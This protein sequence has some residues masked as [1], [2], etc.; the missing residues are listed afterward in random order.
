M[1]R[2]HVHVDAVDLQDGVASGPDGRD[3]D[4]LVEGAH[5]VSVAPQ[6]LRDLKQMAKLDLA[7]DRES[8]DV[9]ADD[10]RDQPLEVRG[11]FRQSPAIEP[12]LFEDRLAREERLGERVAPF[13]VVKQEHTPPFE[14][15]ARE[16]ID[17]LRGREGLARGEG[18]SDSKASQRRRGLW[19]AAHGRDST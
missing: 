13:S 12:L 3:D 1:L 14:L 9:P 16:R 7:G 10:V 8:V 4:P 2:H 17:H 19:T 6:A 11:V 15:H 18:G 5:E